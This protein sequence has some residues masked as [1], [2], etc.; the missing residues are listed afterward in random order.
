MDMAMFGGGD[1]DAVF[2]QLLSAIGPQQLAS[3]LPGDRAVLST[4][5]LARQFALP[6][7]DQAIAAYIQRHNAEW[8]KAQAKAK[9]DSG[10]TAA[11]AVDA[12][13]QGV[14]QFGQSQRIKGQPA[15]VI[16]ILS[17][18]QGMGSIVGNGELSCDLVLYDPAGVELARDRA[19]LGSFFD[20]DEMQELM[21]SA[22]GK[23]KATTDPQLELSPEAKQFSKYLHAMQTA[24]GPNGGNVASDTLVAFKDRLMHPEVFVAYPA[25]VI[26]A[27]AKAKNLQ[28]VASLPDAFAAWLIT[29]MM[30]STTTAS[31]EKKLTHD[32]SLVVDS[33]DGWLTVAPGDFRSEPMD[34]GDLGKILVSL[35][36]EKNP[37]IDLLAAAA[38][39]GLGDPSHGM[40]PEFWLMLASPSLATVYTQDWDML[41]LYGALSVEQR[42]VLMNTKRLPLAA[43]D[44]PQKALVDRMIYGAS[45][46]FMFFSNDAP[47]H[48]DSKREDNS[49]LGAA[50]TMFSDAMAEYGVDGE[51]S[52][53]YRG[54]PTEAAPNGL[55]QGAAITLKISS[56]QVLEPDLKVKSN[57]TVQIYNQP[58]GVEQLAGIV[59]MKESPQFAQMSNYFPKF[60]HV[61]IGAKRSLHF[62]IYVSADSFKAATL[63]DC[64][65]P[66][67]ETYALNG[68]PAALQKKFDA[69]LKQMRDAYK[70]AG[71]SGADGGGVPP[72]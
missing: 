17:R 71:N 2:F 54:E 67:G 51:A 19:N 27:Y 9:Q 13:S 6:P 62:R 39:A 15:K 65:F 33:S 56:A 55:P 66:P 53:D 8:D 23:P 69:A 7:C 37:S 50:D 58:M 35:S 46:G 11:E 16:L 72:R 60:D 31:V 38:L 42:A 57:A 61:L 18:T 70:D 59:A 43:L 24:A 49:I 47:L 36:G 1:G 48:V 40:L 10:E 25:D 52:K 22:T 68:L 4:R 12:E 29:L 30:S 64:A 21:V 3:M 28:L 14:S 44:E 41:R 32:T 20:T 45:S 26:R 5:P 34:R 63:S